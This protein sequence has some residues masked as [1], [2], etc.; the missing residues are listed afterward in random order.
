MIC[1]EYIC[2]YMPISSIPEQ[3]MVT[4]HYGLG[5]YTLYPLYHPC[6][7]SWCSIHSTYSCRNH[8]PP[9]PSREGLVGMRG[10]QKFCIH[11]AFGP[12]RLPSVP[13]LWGVG[14]EDVADIMGFP[15]SIWMKMMW[16][17]LCMGILIVDGWN[18]HFQQYYFGYVGYIVYFAEDW[19]ILKHCEESKAFNWRVWDY[20][21]GSH[22]MNISLQMIYPT[23]DRPLNKYQRCCGVGKRTQCIK[24]PDIDMENL[25]QTKPPKNSPM[26]SR[27]QS[28]LASEAHTCF[29]Q[30]LRCTVPG[31]TGSAVVSQNPG[32]M[33][34]LGWHSLPKT[35]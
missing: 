21:T 5:V 26:D 6:L 2:Q 19:W 1:H 12:E 28:S 11:K 9:L 24:S 31:E 14:R 22:L 7:N 25:P 23:S 10:P 3:A 29:N 34:I 27:L 33:W 16:C 8:G 30:L 35:A 20:C 18:S 4:S 13:R 32:M 17:S 15:L